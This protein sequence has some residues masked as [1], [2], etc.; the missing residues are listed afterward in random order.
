MDKNIN[1]ILKTNKWD[2]SIDL[3]IDKVPFTVIN[4]IT[5]ARRW[6]YDGLSFHRVIEDFMIQ[7]WC[8]LWN[9]TWWPGYMFRDEFSPWLLHNAPGIV[10]MANSWPDTNGSQ[11]FITHVPTSWLDGVHS[12]FGKVVD[13][14]SQDVV[15]N[16]TQWDTIESIIIND[17]NIILSAEAKEFALQI[18]Q[19]LDKDK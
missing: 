4:F 10:S 19:F 11:F 1:I 14:V 9:G 16:I 6:Y 18:N 7:T 5:L 12:V 15:N 8:P 3:F 2:I 13:Q 17:D